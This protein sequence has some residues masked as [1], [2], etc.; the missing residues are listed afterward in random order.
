MNVWVQM[1]KGLKQSDSRWANVHQSLSRA[2]DDGRLVI[3]LSGAHYME[4][5]HRRGSASREDIARLMRDLSQYTTLKPIQQIQRMEI[6]AAAT[7]AF[8]DSPAQVTIDDVLGKGVNHAFNSPLGRL[9]LVESLAE[10][11]IPEGPPSPM[12]VWLDLSALSGPTYE[13][14]SLAGP[15]SMLQFDFDRTPEHRLGSE[16][17]DGEQALRGWIAEDPS[18]RTHLEPV[19]VAEEINSLAADITASASDFDQPPHALL[20][21]AGRDQ[22]EQGPEAGRA[23]VRALP[24]ADAIVTIRVWKHRDNNQPWE[25]HDK[26]DLMALGVAIPYCDVVV[27]ERRW[28][29]MAKA[30][31]LA[32]RYDTLVGHGVGV[33]EELVERLSAN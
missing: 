27:T 24:V 33:L 20:L 14:N 30:T 19:I 13:W 3:P 1:A 9:R 6:D 17:V 23:F 4:L 25:Q 29:H 26:L 16:F 31:R 22:L 2:V 11:G 32:A 21:G 7:V 28:A 8:A 12:P 5:W 15:E 18:R 10:H